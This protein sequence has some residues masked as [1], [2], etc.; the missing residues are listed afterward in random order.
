MLREIAFWSA[1]F[2]GPILFW[3]LL[4]YRLWQVK[5][6]RSRGKV[7]KKP[8]LSAL[9]SDFCLSA[10]VSAL[11][12]YLYFS[13]HYPPPVRGEFSSDSAGDLFVIL[14][15]SPSMRLGDVKPSRWHRA[16]LSI[17]EWT[18]RSDG[19]RAAL[20][21]FG[22]GA[23]LQSPLTRD[24]AALRELAWHSPPG[25][26]GNSSRGF[27]RALRIALEMIRRKPP[28]RTPSY[29]AIFSDGVSAPTQLRV[30]QL[31]RWNVRVAVIA[32]G[33]TSE[34]SD[35]SATAPFPPLPRRRLSPGAGSPLSFRPADL[36]SLKVLA[37]NLGGEFYLLDEFEKKGGLSAVSIQKVPPEDVISGEKNR[38][39]FLGI[40]LLALFF[41]WIYLK[42]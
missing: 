42:K 17:G 8:S 20:I 7:I 38:N 37:Q 25:L 28:P 19:F 12:L 6:L 29:I 30:P 26:Y 23:G 39:I 18:R 3:W 14:D 10:A 34:P 31:A 15:L 22:E 33:S 13:T 9:F 21:A 1:L 36:R 27:V 41:H 35:I 16:V 5:K 4:N 32:V 24:L 11:A 2:S 40:A